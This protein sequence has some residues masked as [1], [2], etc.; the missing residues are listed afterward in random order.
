M[1]ML[2]LII[3]NNAIH[4]A[5]CCLLE[6]RREQRDWTNQISEN[7]ANKH[8]LACLLHSKHQGNH[9]YCRCAHV[10]FY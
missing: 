4:T 1:A 9:H 10:L 8:A 3:A 7:H 2:L 6:E 5:I